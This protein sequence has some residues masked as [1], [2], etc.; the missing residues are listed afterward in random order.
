M[1]ILR[2]QYEGFKTKIKISYNTLAI[3]SKMIQQSNGYNPLI[4]FTQQFGQFIIQVIATQ[5]F[6]YYFACWIN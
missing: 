4:V 6:G 5:V 1:L 2:L 3:S